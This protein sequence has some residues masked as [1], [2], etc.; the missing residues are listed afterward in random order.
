MDK[1]LNTFLL[2]TLT[3]IFTVSSTYAQV[4]V[5]PVT[6][7]PV[8]EGLEEGAPII[9]KDTSSVKKTKYDFRKT[10]NE[11]YPH[12]KTALYLGFAFPGGGQLYNKD[13]WKVPFIWAGYG[14]VTYLIIN[15]GSQYRLLRDAVLIRLSG[16]E[17]MFIN[18]IPSI[19]A[20]R[21][22]RDGAR[23]A[24]EQSYIALVFTHLLVSAEAFVAAHL[25]GFNVSEDV[26][27]KM[28]PDVLL[29]STQ[30]FTQPLYSSIGI[31]VN[32]RVTF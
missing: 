15:N 12:P 23:K 5:D 13:W 2:C 20:L 16:E 21:Q 19:Q 3:V 14:G 27:F 7:F 30:P 24:L 4:E 29:N 9:G 10:F 17:D 26:S 8:E 32:V 25:K 18:T 11:Y 28:T 22:N 6:G 1:L 31:G